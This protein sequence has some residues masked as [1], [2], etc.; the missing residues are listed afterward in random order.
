M[1]TGS[2]LDG[3]GIK[4]AEEMYEI[5]C[6]FPVPVAT[7]SLRRRRR[8]D[9]TGHVFSGP[10]EERD[11]PSTFPC[12]SQTGLHANGATSGIGRVKLS[13]LDPVEQEQ[14]RDHKSG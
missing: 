11:F 10:I 5:P 6:F 3:V 14:Q 4:S 8:C 1:R 12:N 7:K 13:M 9:F 2:G